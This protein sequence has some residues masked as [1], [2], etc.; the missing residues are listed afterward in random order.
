MFGTRPLH[1][2]RGPRPAG[3]VGL[4]PFHLASA[5]FPTPSQL[6]P[7]TQ[8]QAAD[9]GGEVSQEL[10]TCPS[11][12]RECLQGYFC[13]H[14]YPNGFRL[15]GDKYRHGLKSPRG[16]QAGSAGE[17]AAGMRDYK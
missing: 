1:P 3:K 4:C 13:L 14:H 5:T 17:R 12:S 2:Y 9:A 10:G 6:F 7:V 16:R 8:R 11:S 15:S